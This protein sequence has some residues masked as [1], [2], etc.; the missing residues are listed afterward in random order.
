MTSYRVHSQTVDSKREEYRKY[1]ENAG[2]L[3]ILTRVLT[4]LFEMED[5]PDNVLKYVKMQL[6][7]SCPDETQILSLKEEV[8]FL[9]KKIDALEKENANLKFQLAEKQNC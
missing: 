1:L 8:S 9:K 7:A 5:K 6:G 4:D 2:L 3:D